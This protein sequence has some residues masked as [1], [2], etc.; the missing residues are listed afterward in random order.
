MT[1]LFD[2]WIIVADF[3]QEDIVAVDRFRLKIFVKTA[4]SWSAHSLSTLSVTLSEPGA[5]LGLTALSTSLPLCSCTM[6]RGPY[7]SE[8]ECG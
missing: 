4:V 3:R 2:S 5:F 8:G 6:N 7:L 1:V